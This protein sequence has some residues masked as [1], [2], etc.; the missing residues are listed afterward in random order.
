MSTTLGRCKRIAMKQ[1]LT[2]KTFLFAAA[3]FSCCSFLFVN[4]H[5][6]WTTPAVATPSELV[7][8]KG[9]PAVEEEQDHARNLAMPDVT[10]IGRLIELAQRLAGKN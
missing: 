7:A 1:S 9:E 8:P 6:V 3:I 4:I 5:A 2:P 10:V